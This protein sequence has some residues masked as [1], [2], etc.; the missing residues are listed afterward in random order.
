MRTGEVQANLVTL[1]DSFG[2]PYVPDLIARKHAGGEHATLRDAD[3]EFHRGE[4]LRLRAALESAR[5]AS[6][7]PE[8]PTARPVLNDL[9]LRLRLEFNR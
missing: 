1:N 2:L 3:V 5:D 4:Y 6:T 9:L 7:L 8:Q